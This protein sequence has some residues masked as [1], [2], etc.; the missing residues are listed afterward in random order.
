M[1]LRE[2]IRV[3]TPLAPAHAG[4]IPVL[5][6]LT[7]GL[8]AAGF[9]TTSALVAVLPAFAF[10]SQFP[11]LMPFFA[12]AAA[13]GVGDLTTMGRGMLEEWR[14]RL[15]VASVVPYAGLLLVT[16]A[17]PDLPVPSWLA[18]ATGV[19]AGIPFVVCALHARGARRA[20]PRV[21]PDEAAARGTFLIGV[22]LML[23][24]YAVAGPSMTGSIIAVL[25]AVGLALASLLPRGLAHAWGTWRL[26]HW[27]AL[28]GGTLV[29]WASELAS[30]VTTLFSSVW[31]VFAVV[32]A[33]GLPLVLLNA[34][35]QRAA[36]A[37][38]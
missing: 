15:G 5:V 30:A 1:S 10:E 34:A 37:A 18:A 11:V 27:V 13:A 22:A 21:L 38:S 35:E 25:L 20:T 7:A 29:I 8:L 6:H 32:V 31:L 14:S 26:R 33:A 19:L 3:D 4:T 23:M 28:A 9:A 16:A 36:R 24:A 17:V 2:D 12:W